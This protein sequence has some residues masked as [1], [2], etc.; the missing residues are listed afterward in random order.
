[1]II[2]E[3][4]KKNQNKFFIVCIGRALKKLVDNEIRVEMFVAT[5]DEQEFLA[6]TQ[7]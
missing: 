2:L 4:V 3:W 5:L 6:D 1:M 7:F